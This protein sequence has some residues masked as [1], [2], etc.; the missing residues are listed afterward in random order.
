MMMEN[1]S[2]KLLEN[3]HAAVNNEE[4]KKKFHLLI[5]NFDEYEKNRNKQK[6]NNVACH[7]ILLHF[8]LS[9]PTL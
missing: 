9:I 8:V 1:S 4:G 6:R 5:K 2:E 7:L 3:S